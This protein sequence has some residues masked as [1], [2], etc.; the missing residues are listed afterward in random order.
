MKKSALIIVDGLG[1]A[2]DEKGNAASRRT[3]PFLHSLMDE[4][5]F[6]RLEAS[7]AAIG[8]D[9]G[10]A[11]NSEV[12][13]LTIGA[14]RVLPTTLNRIRTAFTNGEWVGA[15]TWNAIRGKQR[16][17]IVG[18]LSDAGVHA[19][20]SSIVQTAQLAAQQNVEKIYL[21]LFLDGVDSAAN[22][23]PGFLSELKLACA[24]IPNVHIGTIS[25]RSWACDRSGDMSISAHCVQGLF[26]TLPHTTFSDDAL[27][28]HLESGKSEA[29]FPFHY[30]DDQGVIQLGD[31]VIL[32]QHRADRLRQ[33]AQALNKQTDLYALIQLDGIV[34]SEHVFFPTRKLSQGLVHTLAEQGINA[35][36]IA[37]SCKFPHVTFFMN[38]MRN[39]VHKHA[40]EIPS[41][42]ESQ[43]LEQPQMCLSDLQQRIELALEDA[44]E[45]ALIINLPNL[46]QV[47]HTGNLML[48]EQAAWHVDRALHV[49][50][51]KSRELGWNLVITADHGNADRMLDQQGKPV[52]S[53]S[54]NPVP[55]LVI[56]SEAQQKPLKSKAG[57]LAN[58]A[59]TFLATLGLT[60][61]SFMDESLIDV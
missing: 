59:A 24:A 57:T 53:H 34:P 30:G 61:P 54:T 5:G 51:S 50:V 44:T 39:D 52:G 4:Y 40:I 23:A 21:H 49:L 19:H 9:E 20:W 14:G 3:M 41:I 36:R 7:G 8:L 32:T 13:H 45:R 16:V 26:G 2:G 10:Q 29:S 42:P 35:T 17:H 31:T 6:A 46:D 33:L 48:A 55:L 27:R 56:R 47:G 18:L 22:T 1:L 58:V 43:I 37:E 15:P 38:G 25:G 11:G 28:A 12:G 60:A